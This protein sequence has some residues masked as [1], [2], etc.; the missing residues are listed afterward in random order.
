MESYLC[1]TGRSAAAHICTNRP[2]DHHIHIHSLT[3]TSL[4]PLKPYMVLVV[5]ETR[6]QGTVISLIISH[7]KLPGSMVSMFFI[8]WEHS[9]KMYFPLLFLATMQFLS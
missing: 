8:I 2:S 1:S 5:G 4:K 6:A 3:S 9:S 7:C